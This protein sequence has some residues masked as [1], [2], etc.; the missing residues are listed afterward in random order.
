MLFRSNVV[1]IT[2]FVLHETGQPLHAFDADKIDGRKILI[3]K[4]DE[5]T[6]FKTLDEVDRKLSKDD[7]MICNVNQG[8]C[9]AGVFGG[10][11]SGVTEKSE[12]IFLE[13]AYFD[14]KTIRKTAKRHELNTDASFRF[15]R[16]ADPNITVYALKRAALLL[17]EIAGGSISSE[18]V[19][20]YP[21]KIEDVKVKFNY[22][23]ADRL[24]GQRIRRDVIK[25]IFTS[26]EI[27]VRDESD[28][29]L[30][31]LIPPYRVDVT[32]EVD[33]IEEV[34]RI[35]GYKN[36][37]ISDTAHLTFA[38]SSHNA[39]NVTEVVSELLSSS[40]FSELMRTEERRVGHEFRSRWSPYQ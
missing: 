8:M 5:G 26:L 3:K 4:L 10:G 27:E 13:S 14:P 12:S 37:E 25:R 29:H 31:V 40:G 22:T 15:E 20:I 24:I 17:K 21:K 38:T 9:I 11:D 6:P 18:I 30:E 16:G 35:Y 34:L 2:N 36:I 33:L 23:K 39:A 1:D 7:L 32:R 28:D 19:D